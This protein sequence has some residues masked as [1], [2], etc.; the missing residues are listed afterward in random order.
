MFFS[1][2][3]KI[4][5]EINRFLQQLNK[6]PRTNDQTNLPL[7]IILKRPNG[8]PATA[9]IQQQKLF[10]QWLSSHRLLSFPILRIGILK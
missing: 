9:F 10:I 2:F 6:M 3:V 4:G 1:N 5:I 7:P 8:I